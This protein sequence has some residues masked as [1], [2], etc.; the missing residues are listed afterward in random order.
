MSTT[1]T[2][3]AG[4]SLGIVDVDGHDEQRDDR[5]GEVE[6]VAAFLAHCGG[7]QDRAAHLRRCAR[8]AAAARALDP[9]DEL[10]PDLE[11]RLMRSFRDW[12]ERDA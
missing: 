5:T 1:V 2:D 11:L 7:T 3:G 9:D 8:C 12:R 6:A 4:G 10:G